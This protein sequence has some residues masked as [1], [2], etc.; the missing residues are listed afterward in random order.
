MRK[1][2]RLIEESNPDAANY[3]LTL[4][5]ENQAGDV[6]EALERE[7]S[8]HDAA[9]ELWAALSDI[10]HP[11]ED[12]GDPAEAAVAEIQPGGAQAVQDRANVEGG[13]LQKY[14]GET[15]Q[16]KQLGAQM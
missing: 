12:E 13:I 10:F 6:D 1:F 7:I 2:L 4:T 3:R 5:I 14:A 8:G 11:A 15:A 16:L 9:G